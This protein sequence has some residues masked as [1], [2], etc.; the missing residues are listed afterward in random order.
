MV[1]FKG[2]RRKTAGSTFA[3]SV[4]RAQAWQQ[5]QGS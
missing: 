1:G 4:P 5:T 3:A 2:Q